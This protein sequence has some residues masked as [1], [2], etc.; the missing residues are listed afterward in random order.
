MIN[1]Q[2]KLESHSLDCGFIGFRI[3]DGIA[4]SRDSVALQTP[5][6]TY[7]VRG[8]FSL[9]DESIVFAVKPKARK[10]IGLSA[11]TLTNVVRVTGTFIES[12]REVDPEGVATTGAT[13]GLA[14]MTG[15]LSILAQGLFDK[16]TGSGDVCGIA[17]SNQQLLLAEPSECVLNKW[18][19]LQLT[20]D[21]RISIDADTSSCSR[22]V[23]DI[24]S[25]RDKND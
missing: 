17:N 13:W 11:A 15:G 4:M 7:L 9:K 10:G 22:G 21:S 6:V 25:K 20:T 23:D 14:A 3:V 19:Q 5:D 12:R 18:N 8:G 2:E 16:F 1:P 24:G